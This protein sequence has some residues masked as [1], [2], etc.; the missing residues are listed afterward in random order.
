MSKINQFYYKKNRMQQIR[1][2]CYTV[3]QGSMIKASKIMCLDPSTISLQINSLE[4]DLKTKLF[5]RN[6]KKL[7]K[8]TKKGKDF[9]KRAIE[10]LQ[11][12]ENLFEGFNKSIID[13]E[14]NKLTIA[15]HYT[16]LSYTLPKYIKILT[17]QTRFKN[18]EIKLCNLHKQEAFERLINKDIDIAIYPS[19][20]MEKPPIELEMKSIFD[21][22]TSIFVNKNHPLA[23]KNKLEKEDIE[24][25]EF[26]LIDKYTFY[27]PTKIVNFKKSN[28]SFQNGNSYIVLGLVRENIAIGCGSG[29]FLKNSFFSK[30][31]VFKNVDHIFPKMY[32]SSFVLKNQQIRKE[33]LE[34]LINEFEKDN[35]LL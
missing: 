35:N 5:I 1:G 19:M 11:G 4:R 2:F 32:I 18:L 33:S 29:I 9:Y 13:K 8:L 23:K 7:L 25:Y 22:K 15:G 16:L 34:F 3:Q 28:I 21:F 14:K 10:L 6:G 24:N 20:I 26:L 12:V 31:I 17:S 27:D 30:D